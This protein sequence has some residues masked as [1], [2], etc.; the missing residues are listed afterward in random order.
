MQLHRTAGAAHALLVECLECHVSLDSGAG[1]PSHGGVD[2]CLASLGRLGRVQEQFPPPFVP[3]AELAAGCPATQLFLRRQVDMQ[4]EDLRLL[5]R[6]PAEELDPHVG[7]NLT[8]AAMML[9]VIS[10]FSRWF[11]HTEVATAIAAEEQHGNPQSA[12][13][14]KGFVKE[15]WP[16]L[17]PEPAPDGV[18]KRLY[19]I[20]NS[21]SHDLGVRDEPNHKDEATIRLAKHKMTLDEIV[22]DLERNLAHPLKVSIIEEQVDGSL[23]HLSG[24]YWALLYMLRRALEDRPR[25][26][27]DALSGISWPEIEEVAG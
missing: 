25:E 1:R 11:F 13:R 2:S 18:A 17:D 9:N 6:L 7:C 10:G 20:R 27:E 16:R 14:F 22:M 24:L 26:I 21:L 23:V 12:K 4:V 8:A 5:C 19:E 3:S 15:Y